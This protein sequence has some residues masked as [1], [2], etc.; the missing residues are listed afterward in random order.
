MKHNLVWKPQSP[1]PPES[2]RLPPSVT[3]RGSALKK[4]V[5]PGPVIEIP[6][7]AKKSKKKKKVQNRMKSA[8]PMIKR[9]KNM[10][11]RSP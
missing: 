11:T 5:P 1:L 4:G 10:Q 9:R 8:T 6:S 3:P 7:S 2:L